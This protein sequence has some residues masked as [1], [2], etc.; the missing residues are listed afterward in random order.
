MCHRHSVRPGCGRGPSTV[1]RHQPQTRPPELSTCP[2]QA[3][4]RRTIHEHGHVPVLAVTDGAAFPL[5]TAPAPGAPLPDRVADAHPASFLESAPQ[6]RPRPGWHSGLP[7][8]R[9]PR[10]PVAC[11]VP[12][13]GA[14]G[15]PGSAPAGGADGGSVLQRAGQP[16]AV[17]SQRTGSHCLGG[18]PV[19]TPRPELRSSEGRRARPGCGGRGLWPCPGFHRSRKRPVSRGSL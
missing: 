6:R 14:L 11:A 9:R 18:R 1:S 10:G 2:H 7:S 8:T 19:G 15:H 5:V 3:E 4:H 17:L 16:W 13:H 12:L